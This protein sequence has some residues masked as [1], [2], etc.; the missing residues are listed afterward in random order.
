MSMPSMS[1]FLQRGEG[2]KN[3]LGV[4]VLGFSTVR[5]KFSKAHRVSLTKVT[6][7]S[8]LC[9]VTFERSPQGIWLWSK[10]HDGFENLATRA[11]GW[12]HSWNQRLDW[13]IFRLAQC[14]HA[15]TPTQIHTYSLTQNSTE[16]ALMNL[17]LLKYN[18][19]TCVVTVTE[20]PVLLQNSQ[21]GSTAH[22]L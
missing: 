19:V 17:S 5:K 6:L 2:R 15:C 20:E 22:P 14:K 1:D 8:L 3:R 10:C 12:L 7:I 18:S 4:W 21:W 11:I 13:C 16:I 9:S